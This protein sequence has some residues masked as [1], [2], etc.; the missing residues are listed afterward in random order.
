[1]RSIRALQAELVTVMDGL[2]EFSGLMGV[3]FVIDIN[4]GC[5]MSVVCL[6]Q[7]LQAAIFI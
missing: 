4:V 1:M 3:S 5:V 2:A 7:H 6:S